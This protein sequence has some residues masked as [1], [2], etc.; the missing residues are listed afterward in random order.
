MF[1]KFENYTLFKGTL[2]KK[3]NAGAEEFEQAVSYFVENGYEK[4]L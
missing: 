2:Y 1:E 3:E 4:S